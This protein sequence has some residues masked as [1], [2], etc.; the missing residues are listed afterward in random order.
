MASKPKQVAFLGLMLSIIMVLVIAER[1]LPPL[2]FLP[3]NFGIGLSNIIIMYLL[4]F[5]G[6]RKTLIMAVLK[7]MFNLMI[8]G[9]MSG[10]LSLTG[11]FFSVIV[12]SLASRLMGGK[13]S[14]ITLSVLGAVA[15]NAGQVIVASFLLQSPLLLVY[16]SPFLFAVGLLAGFLTGISMNVLMPIF[17]RFYNS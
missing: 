5:F 6:I 4:F 9:P 12:I 10:I 15:H 16:Y 14:Y 8:R 3:P 7:A 11:G 1:M 2:P 17:N 13:V